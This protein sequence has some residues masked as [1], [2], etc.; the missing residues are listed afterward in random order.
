MSNVE[1]LVPRGIEDRFPGRIASVDERVRVSVLEDDGS[2]GGAAEVLLRGELRLEA[3][4]RALEAHPG[5]EWMHLYSAGVEQLLPQLGKYDG[6]LTNSGGVH[7]EPIAE[8]VIL[9]LL[10][11]C[12]RMPLL[13]D[14]HRA[15]EWKPEESEEL[16]G[17]TLGIVGAGGIGGA[18]AR[19]AAALDVR[20]L[21][22]RASG[23]PGEHIAR[24]YTPDGLH[25]L[26]GECDFVVLATPLTRETEGMIGE[27]ELR[28]MR[29]AA[30]ILNIARG[31][32]IQTDP[33]VR[34]LTEGWIAAAYL[35]VT[36]PEPLPPDHPLWTLPNALITAHTSGH[37]PRSDERLIEFFC[38]NLRHWLDGEPLENVVDRERGY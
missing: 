30:A 33:L 9:M 11:H 7:A 1:V 17:K 36:D 8:W 13:L 26:L 6:I 14:H 21:G 23:Q 25:E 16:G 28:A 35:D 19:R 10:A 3:T 24:M 22:L 2:G 12:K 5:I 34:A 4:R 38:R 18:I 27:G 31:K 20:V 15:R 37:S 29:P 32:V